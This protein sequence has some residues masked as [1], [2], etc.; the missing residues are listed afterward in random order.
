MSAFTL[1]HSAAARQRAPLPQ[2]PGHSAVEMDGSHEICRP[3]SSSAD[4]LT[5]RHGSL[6]AIHATS[7][8]PAWAPPSELAAAVAIPS[9][10]TTSLGSVRFDLPRRPPGTPPPPS[11]IGAAAKRRIAVVDH[12]H[13]KSHAR[14]EPMRAHSPSSC[15]ASATDPCLDSATELERHLDDEDDG[16]DEDGQAALITTMAARIASLEAELDRLREMQADVAQSALAMGEPP[17]AW[18]AALVLHVPLVRSQVDAINRQT[19]PPPAQVVVEADGSHHFKQAP[20]SLVV[21]QDGIS[22]AGQSFMLP[23]PEA[24]QILSDLAEGYLPNSLKADYPNGA[25]LEVVDKAKWRLHDTGALAAASA[26][27]LGSPTTASA[28]V[29]RGNDT[30]PRIRLGDPSAAD[31]VHFKLYSDSGAVAVIECARNA[32]VASVVGDLVDKG[33]LVRQTSKSLW[34][35]CGTRSETLASRRLTGNVGEVCKGATL[36]WD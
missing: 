26:G 32:T 28:A 4:R 30:I 20:V 33:V 22:I 14:L 29:R 7:T 3:T 9:G 6:P 10:L 13:I 16:D 12:V 21:Y 24:L 19:P 2:L 17:T 36:W 15:K 34:I 35:R 27:I 25:R 23:H 1:G 11:M 18:S 31:I 8:V 5:S